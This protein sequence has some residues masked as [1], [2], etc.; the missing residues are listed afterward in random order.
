M[1]KYR[2]FI[3]GIIVGI[4]IFVLGVLA[5]GGG[6]L[7]PSQNEYYKG[8][9]ESYGKYYKIIKLIDETALAEYDPEEI[10]DEVLKG[11]VS[12]LDDKYAEYFTAEEYADYIKRYSKSYVGIGVVVA[13]TEEGATVAA[14]VEGGPAEEVGMQ[15]G[16][17][18]VSVDGEK[19]S[20]STEASDAI[21]G[22]NGTEVSITVLRDGETIDYVLNRTKIE[23]KTVGYEEYDEENKIGYIRISSFGSNTAKEFRLAV[24]DLRNAGY[25]KVI[26]DLRSNGG[27][28]TEQ[29]Y[30]IADY[31]LPECT[32]IKEV[33]KAGDETVRKSAAGTLGIDYVLLV[34]GNSASASEIVTAAVK[35][36]NGGTIIGTTTYGKGVTQMTT[37]FDDGSALKITV[38]EFF[39]PNGEK[40]DGVGIEPDIVVEDTNDDKALLEIACGE[41]LK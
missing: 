17:V 27:G 9:S 6:I 1:K 37:K 23:N 26:I 20:D 8:L 7:G 25:E 13:T 30:K 33:D 31:L 10:N 29:A 41:L 38:E 18:I 16:D 22:D 24:K 34:D 19:V 28:R 32:T 4:A 21:L 12:E 15:I 3:S 36:N 39:G 11:I 40:I 5:I 35:Y 14:V 2:P